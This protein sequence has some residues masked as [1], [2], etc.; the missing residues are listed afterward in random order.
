MI[1][2]KRRNS[3]AQLNR[4]LSFDCRAKT[5]RLETVRGENSGIGSFAETDHDPWL[6]EVDERSQKPR[7]AVLKPLTPN[8]CL[9]T[10]TL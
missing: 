5:A 3:G 8:R 9:G 6:H 10:A 4:L 1:N 2:G 7:A